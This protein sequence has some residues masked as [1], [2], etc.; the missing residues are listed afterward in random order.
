MAHDNDDN[1]SWQWNETIEQRKT[2]QISLQFPSRLVRHCNLFMLCSHCFCLENKRYNLSLIAHNDVLIMIRAHYF[3][4]F[5]AEFFSVTTI[6]WLLHALPPPPS[7]HTSYSS[8]RCPSRP[9]SVGSC[10]VII[11]R[12]WQEWE[13]GF[14]V[15]PCLRSFS[16][17]SRLVRSQIKAI[18]AV[19]VTSTNFHPLC[20]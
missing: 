4:S 20:P 3:I 6:P 13:R 8:R 2:R 7:A 12:L 15:R 9:P 10:T 5:T 14:T 19:C 1:D 11:C 17:T 16:P 18:E